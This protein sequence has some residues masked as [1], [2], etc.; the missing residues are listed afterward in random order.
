VIKIFNI[1]HDPIETDLDKPS[2]PFS[3]SSFILSDLPLV[4][5]EKQ[6]RRRQT[7]LPR[8]S[9]ASHFNPMNKATRTSI[10]VQ[11][12]TVTVLSQNQQ[13]ISCLTNIAKFKNPDHPDDAIRNWLRTRSTV[14]FLG[15]WKR[16]NNPSFNSLEFEGIKMQ[17]GLNIFVLC[18]NARLDP[19]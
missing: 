4:P 11:G 9:R 12:G 13:E 16:L 3:T 1:H 7:R 6:R 17:T 19:T 5:R 10:E 14:E 2:C 15:V 8:P 18:L